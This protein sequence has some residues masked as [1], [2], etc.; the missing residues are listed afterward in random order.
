[1]REDADDADLLAEIAQADF[2]R[3]RMVLKARPACRF[4]MTAPGVEAVPA[5]A[6]YATI[7]DISRFSRMRDIGAYLGLTPRR[8]QSADRDVTLGI[9]R[10][11]DKMAR[12]YLYEAANVLLTTVR[13]LG[14]EEPGPG[15]DEAGGGQEG[16]YC[17]SSPP[18]GAVEADMEG[19]EPF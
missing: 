1:L 11:G 15:L 19:A 18:A 14:A 12:H 9:F 6:C 3:D 17:G 2:F 16:P 8:Y 5:L 13:A 4:L 7:K 10:W